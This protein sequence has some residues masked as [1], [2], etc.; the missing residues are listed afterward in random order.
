[1]GTYAKNTQVSVDRSRAEIERI[2]S[3]YGAVGF[4]SGWQ[5]NPSIAVIGFQIDG[6]MVKIQLPLPDANAKEFQRTETG[7]PRARATAEKAWEQSCRQ[8]WRA[9]CLIVKA[10][11]EA[12][13][14][15]ISTIERE[16]LADVVLPDGTTLGE[17]VAPQ[18]DA[19]VRDRAMPP[20]LP[21]VKG[22]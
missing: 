4:V 17:W 8:R 21:G 14:A 6:R 2:L 19:I 15:G 5:R 11:L 9:L 20:L 13:D 1:M 10:K 3:R 22:T 12:V 18:M 7:R 16:F